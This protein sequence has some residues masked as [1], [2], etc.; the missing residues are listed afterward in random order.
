[1]VAFTAF[2]NITGQ[3]AISLPLH[4]TGD[5]V[6][7]GAQLTGGPWDEAT[8]IRLAAHLEHAAPW[9]GQRPDVD[10]LASAA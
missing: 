2:S 4:R 6:P 8:L 5:G 1:M 10:R 7:I 9:A 3:P